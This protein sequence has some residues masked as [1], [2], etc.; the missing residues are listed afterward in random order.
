MTA[1]RIR[2]LVPEDRER[3]ES[4]TRGTG[5]FWDWEI[6]IALEVFDDATGANPEGRI[7]PDYESA[8]LEADGRL[9]GWACWGPTPGHPG[10]FDLYWIVV[11]ASAQGRGFGSALLAEMDRRIAGRARLILVETSGRP[12][13]EATRAFYLRHG[14][15]PIDR[16]PDHFGPG[17]DLVRFAK[18]V[19]GSSSG[20][21][22]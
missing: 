18:D 15:R 13:Y 3:V 17:D 8:G 19:I 1:P 14:Y 12:D 10:Q 4:M 5:L 2:P 21:G 20:A 16:V 22:G 11:D 6:P 9:A 7:D